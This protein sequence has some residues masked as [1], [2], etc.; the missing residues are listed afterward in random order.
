MSALAP[1]AGD[2]VID[3]GCGCG[4]TTL[5]LAERVT[6]SGSVLGVDVSAPMLA[7][8]RERAAAR[9]LDHV[10][11]VAADAQTHRL[12]EGGSDAIF[13]RFGVMFFADPTA[14]FTNLARAL[15]PGG[16]VAFVCWQAATENPWVMVPLMA[17]AGVVTLPPP[18]APGAPGPFAFADA[19]RVRSILDGAGLREV[20]IEP[21]TPPV[22]MPG[23]LDEGVT[24]ATE[25]GPTSAALRDAPPDVVTKARAAVREA[26][27]E[28]VTSRGVALAS[29]A[30]VVSARR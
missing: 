13:S 10:R 24:F 19:D 23:G 9:G 25:V 27:A 4:T 29:A 2:R 30:W 26:L 21:C 8:A 11:F 6:P 16:R 15:V 18:P 17:I 20:R 7:R 14:A 1:R 22:V 3:V 28:H 12:P 5:A